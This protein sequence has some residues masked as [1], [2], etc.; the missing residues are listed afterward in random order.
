METLMSSS[1]TP[2]GYRQNNYIAGRP[3]DIEWPDDDEESSSESEFDGKVE[4]DKLL[5]NPSSGDIVRHRCRFLPSK[6]FRLLVFTWKYSASL[7][8]SG[9]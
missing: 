4:L 7:H 6:T 1:P 3:T 8:N 2:A 9:F 5:A